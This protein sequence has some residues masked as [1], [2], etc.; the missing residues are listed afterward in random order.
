MWRW[1]GGVQ[2][3]NKGKAPAE[4]A[5]FALHDVV[6]ENGTTPRGT[7]TGMKQ[8][9]AWAEGRKSMKGHITRSFFAFVVAGLVLAPVA[10]NFAQG[11]P[12]AAPG[13]EAVDSASTPGAEWIKGALPMA[14]NRFIHWDNVGRGIYTIYW[15]VFIPPHYKPGAE[16]PF[17]DIVDHPLSV[18]VD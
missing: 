13:P 3:V 8:A 9:A 1:D 15:Y 6:R 5:S 18:T 17:L 2:R 11:A 16:K 4:G 7:L 14:G 10:K 12:P